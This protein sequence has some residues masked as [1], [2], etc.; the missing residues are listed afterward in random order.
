VDPL[1]VEPGEPRIQSLA[2]AGRNGEHRDV[3]IDPVRISDQGAEIGIHVRREVD[4]VHQDQAGR[5]K[6]VGIFERLVVALGHRDDRHLGGLPKVKG[7]GTDKISDILDEQE[8]VVERREP[9]ERMADHV[10]VEMTSLAGIDL[11]RRRPRRAY[12]VSI[13]R[14]LLIALDDGNGHAVRQRCNGADQQRGLSRSRAGN[15]IERHRACGGEMLAVAR[16]VPVILGQNVALERDRPRGPI[17]VVVRRVPMIVAVP[18]AMMVPVAVL[19]V[20][21]VIMAVGGWSR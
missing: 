13:D 14:G 19:V 15:E 2:A 4:L 11:H 12:A 3:G 21:L 20:A 17:I 7:G 16:R 5:S 10:G 9:I 18:V 1:R 6:D 8:A